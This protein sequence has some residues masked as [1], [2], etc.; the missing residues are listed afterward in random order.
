MKHKCAPIYDLHMFLS[1]GMACNYADNATV[2]ASN[3]N[4]EEITR[5][6]E[7]GITF[8]SSW[9]R[10]NFMKINK[11]K[12]HLLY[13]SNV[14]SSNIA[15][16]TSNKLIHETSEEKLQESK[17]NAACYISHCSLY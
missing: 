12:C 9:F 15:I 1:D 5:K 10:D 17:P 13:F 8:L 2:Y 14:K 4:K 11:E 16:K 7:N 3:Y 6:S